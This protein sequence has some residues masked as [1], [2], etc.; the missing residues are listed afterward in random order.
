MENPYSIAG[1][2]LTTGGGGGVVM[3]ISGAITWHFTWQALKLP[4]ILPGRAL[5]CHKFLKNTLNFFYILRK[6][7]ITW[8]L[9]GICHYLAFTWQRV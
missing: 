9:P 5:T 3:K 7:Q 8:Q 6:G 1:G 4:G 2:R